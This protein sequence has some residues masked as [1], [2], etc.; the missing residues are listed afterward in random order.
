METKQS[1]QYITRALVVLTVS[2]I[3]S[4][5][6]AAGLNTDVALTPPEGG[7]II[8][9]Q[10]RYSELSDDPTPLGRNVDR[11]V[12]P[13]TAVH[14]VTADFSLLATV[15]IIYREI[16]FDNQ[17]RQID[18]GFGDIP[19]LGKYRF[20]QKDEPGV[21]TRMAAIGGAE[22]PTFDNAFSSESLDPIIG[23]VWT[24]QRKDWWIDWDVLYTFNTAD[25]PDGDDELRAD[26]AYTH[27]L[28]GGESETIGPWGLYAI[29]EINARYLT[30]GST[31]IF[32]SPGV[33]YITPN[34]IL[35]AGVQW[36]AAQD[37]KS[38]RLETDYTA[39]VSVR[40]Q[41]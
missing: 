20:Y 37:M 24:H 29:G 30:D 14:G 19:V 2:V 7:W 39:V 3:V 22:I 34:L 6:H 41:Y 12:Q 36:P 15:P 27:R 40:F 10:W 11:S 21:T 16:K 32:I 5:A 31:Q 26:V 9:A 25:G 8:R 38:P 17:P 1:L 35:E 18:R 23:A 33:Q 28:L 4:S 13:I